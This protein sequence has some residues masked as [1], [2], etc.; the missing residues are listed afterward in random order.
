MARG[1]HYAQSVRQ[2]HRPRKGKPE[3]IKEEQTMTYATY[4]PATWL[5]QFFSDFDRVPGVAKRGF[6]PPVDIVEEKEEFVLRAELP[7]VA[8]ENIKIEVKE[9]RLTLSGRKE[10]ALAAKSEPSANGDSNAVGTARGQYRYAESHYGAFSRAFELP[11]NA[12]GEAIRAEY[13]DGVLTL[14]IPKVKEALPRTIAIE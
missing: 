14:R 12:Q 1:L 2:L 11:R 4:S 13:K 9:N 7:G 5:D 3:T 8:R 6:N 10:N